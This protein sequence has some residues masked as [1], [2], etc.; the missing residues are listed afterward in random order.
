MTPSDP[1]PDA[2]RT[3]ESPGLRVVLPRRPSSPG[4]AAI[5]AVA[6]LLFGGVPSGMVAAALAGVPLEGN[7]L[8]PV[9]LVLF[10]LPF[11]AVALLAL[12]GAARALHSR[13]VVELTPDSLRVV[14]RIG[15]LSFARRRDARRLR[16]IALDEHAP[17]RG[18]GGPWH[19]RWGLRATFR[20][21]PRLRF[22]RGYER[23]RLE[24]VA[25]HL[26]GAAAEWG[27]DVE[28]RGCRVLEEQGEAGARREVPTG[29]PSSPEPASLPTTAEV[30][31]DDARLAVGGDIRLVRTAD[32]VVVLVPPAGWRGSLGLLPIGAGFVLLGGFGTAIAIAGEGSARGA[33]VTLP[34]AV[35]GGVLLAIGRNLG[36][37]RARLAVDARELV[38]EQRGSFGRRVRRFPLEEV[39]GVRVGPSGMR[40]NDRP[41]MELQVHAGGRKALGL[42]AQREEAECEAV[43]DALHRAIF[44]P[45]SGARGS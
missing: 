25:R 28:A 19:E 15:P 14:E 43:A 1:T 36:Q 13:C 32:G 33:L 12:A 21:G 37:R 5:L 16:D 9:G 44:A 34:F 39:E 35:L 29:A 42:L 27:A 8:G 24:E 11:L 26:A 20:D 4:R 38:V 3:P 7:A 22:A 41:V 17:P 10:C 30:P 18:G 31:L 23:R 6:A 2:A 40:V 45:R